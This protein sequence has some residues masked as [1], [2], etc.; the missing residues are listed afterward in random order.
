[1]I[2]LQM[3]P[4]VAMPQIGG[5]QSSSALGGIDPMFMQM[6]IHKLMMK[7][8]GSTLTN[9]PQVPSAVPGMMGGGMG[10]LGGM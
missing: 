5:G 6:L 7:N 4:D 2:P 8:P 10:T 3:P 9:P 1:M